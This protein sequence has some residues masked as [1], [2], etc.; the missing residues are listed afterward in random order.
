M[1]GADGVHAEWAEGSKKRLNGRASAEPYE[2]HVDHIPKTLHDALCFSIDKRSNTL[3]DQFKD[4]AARGNVHESAG[5]SE[6]NDTGADRVLSK[7]FFP[8]DVFPVLKPLE[9]VD[10]LFVGRGR[11]VKARMNERDSE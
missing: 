4:P 5:Q 11:A 8:R 2:A 7:G 1:D 9:E 3:D 10:A 6:P